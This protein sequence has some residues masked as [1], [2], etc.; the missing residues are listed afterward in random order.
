MTI[1]TCI[2][3]WECAFPDRV[4][5]VARVTTRILPVVLLV[6]VR[7]SVED[8][9]RFPM[10]VR[11][12]FPALGGVRSYIPSARMRELVIRRV[13]AMAHVAGEALPVVCAAGEVDHRD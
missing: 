9:C 6:I 1:C 12:A 5:A 2:G 4:F 10:A 11:A 8:P 13:A 7:T 3:N